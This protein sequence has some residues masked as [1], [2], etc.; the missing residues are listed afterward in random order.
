MAKSIYDI[1]NVGHGVLNPEHTPLTGINHNTENA[2]FFNLFYKT[3][4][5]KNNSKRAHF[6]GP[7][8]GIC[9]RNEGRVSESG[10]IDPTCWAA[11]SKE[12]IDS[13][14]DLDLV[15]VRVRIPELHGHL[16]IPTDLPDRSV[17][18]ENHDIINQYPV[19]ISQQNVIAPVAGDLVWVDFQDRENK[20]GP[21]FLGVAEQNNYSASSKSEEEAKGKES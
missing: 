1:L 14:S 5:I 12:I 7:M 6:S 20:L 9:L 10:F 3:I 13:G 21:I 8:V 17:I 4:N 19:F 16:R 11:A 2:S 18:D 15:Q